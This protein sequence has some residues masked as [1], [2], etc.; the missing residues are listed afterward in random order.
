MEGAYEEVK[1]LDSFNFNCH[2]GCIS[3]VAFGFKKDKKDEL[4]LYGNIEIREVNLSFRVSGRLKE[5]Y[6]E[7]GDYVKKRADFSKA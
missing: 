5:L 4:L 1:I 2:Y 3:F 7:E 6:F